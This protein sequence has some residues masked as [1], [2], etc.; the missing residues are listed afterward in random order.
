MEDW[1][2]CQISPLVK[3]RQKHNQKSYSL[4]EDLGLFITGTLIYIRLS[5]EYEFTKDY[6]FSSVTY[7]QY[8]SSRKHYLVVAQII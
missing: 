4:K 8:I 1:L 3:Y 6:H 5:K 2:K 7:V